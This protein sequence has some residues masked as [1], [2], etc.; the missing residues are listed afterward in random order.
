MRRK[1]LSLGERLDVLALTQPISLP[2]MGIA[3]HGFPSAPPSK[4]G[5]F[6][7]GNASAMGPGFSQGLQP[8]LGQ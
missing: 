4:Q 3:D 2:E 1:G 6:P 8:Q 7:W 5:W